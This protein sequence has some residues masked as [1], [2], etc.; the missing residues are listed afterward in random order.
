MSEHIQSQLQLQSPQM[1]EPH[2]VHIMNMIH[3]IVA[4]V[5]TALTMHLN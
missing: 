4:Q 1:K 2:Q 3:Q 5:V